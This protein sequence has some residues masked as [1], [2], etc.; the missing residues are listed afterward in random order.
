ML[1][2]SLQQKKLIDETMETKKRDLTKVKIHDLKWLNEYYGFICVR[3]KKDLI[4]NLIPLQKK[5]CK[6][7]EI[8]EIDY[9][10]ECPVCFCD[11]PKTNVFIS[12]CVHVFCT[13]CIIRHTIICDQTCP[14]CRSRCTYEDITRNYTDKYI[15]ELLYRNGIMKITQSVLDTGLVL[16]Q[17]M[18]NTMNN[19]FIW[20][21]E[22]IDKII[23][24][25]QREKLGLGIIIGLILIK[26]VIHLYPIVF[27]ITKHE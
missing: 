3:K 14:I 4:K 24:H 11:I 25:N 22:L 19:R 5:L 18:N 21:K 6:I 20:D 13:D 27:I 9:S 17:D 2:L 7:R 23:K 12:N 10:V 15:Q 1:S 8:S 26:I 16:Q